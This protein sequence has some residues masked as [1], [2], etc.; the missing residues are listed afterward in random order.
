MKIGQSGNKDAG[1]TLMELMIVVTII[2]ILLA[3][4][5]PNYSESIRKSRRSDAIKELMEL[6]SQQERFY[7]QNSTYTEDIETAAGLNRGTDITAKQGCGT[8]QCR[9]PKAQI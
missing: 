2:G 6:A 8:D 9:A 1:F 4:V 7:A 3:I 5:M